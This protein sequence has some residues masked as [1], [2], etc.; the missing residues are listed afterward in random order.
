[1]YQK[2]TIGE[3]AKILGVTTETIRHYERK[4][5]IKPVHDQET[6]YRYY[7]TWDLHMLLRAR[8]YLGFGFSAEQTAAILQ[9]ND[10]NK[11]D[12][13]LEQQEMILQEKILY[14]MNILK[15][16]RKN[17]QLIRDI[18]NDHSMLSIRERPGIYRIDT[19]KCYTISLEQDELLELKQ[20]CQSVPFIFSTA[21]FPQENLNNKNKEFYFGVGIEEEFASLLNIKCSKYIKYYPPTLCLYMC[22]PSR[23]GKFLNYE[24]LKPAFDYMK[25]HNLILNGD[26]I[27]QIVWMSKPENEYFNWHNIWIPIK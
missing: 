4:K 11:L 16:I 24:V 21:L 2:Y 9:N 23:S 25:K 20:F 18:L 17:R 8:C 22:I 12:L 19:Q 26:I 15:K 5:L 3:L 1:M 7:N 27:T 13:L 14:N 6:G 10:L